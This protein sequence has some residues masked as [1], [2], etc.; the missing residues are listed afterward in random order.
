MTGNS[1]SCF[2]SNRKRKI[3]N[4]FNTM[5]TSEGIN[6]CWKQIFKRLDLSYSEKYFSVN[7]KK[8][9]YDYS[10]Q[11]EIQTTDDFL[12]QILPCDE[13]KMLSIHDEEAITWISQKEA[14][15]EPSSA[16]PFANI[17]ILFA[18]K[19]KPRSFASIKGNVLQVNADVIATIFF[20][21]TRYEEI[22]HQ[23]QDRFGRYPYHAS[24]IEKFSLIDIPIVDLYILILKGW[25]EK[26]TSETIANPKNF[27]ILLTH[28]IDM[29]FR[30]KPFSNF[31]RN[32]GKSILKFQI[33]GFYQNLKQFFRSYE[34]DDYFYGIRKI[35]ETSSRNGLNSVFNLMATTPGKR[36]EGYKL[37]SALMQRVINKI[38]GS[39][40]EIG[41]HPSFRS[42]EEPGLVEK[43]KITLEK[44]IRHDVKGGRQHYL[45]VKTPE[46]WQIWQEA[47]LHYDNSYTFAEHEGFRCGTCFPYTVFDV[48][49]NKELDFVELPLI[50]MDTTLKNYRKLSIDDAKERIFHLAK[51]CKFVGGCF[52]LLWHNSS[53]TQSWQKWGDEYADIIKGLSLLKVKKQK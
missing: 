47:G 45:R 32:A 30:N 18:K 24:V 19:A 11:P 51:I 34:D 23:G 2:H 41:L 28:D 13:Q 38:E 52:T 12:L 5:L 40:F 36:D 15:S 53:F 49:Q 48:T 17:P 26:L 21:L 10:K 6:Y 43:E 37:G 31:V 20:F 39:G 42:F 35:T 44:H 3:H 4:G 8:I 29:P 1:K 27:E 33:M 22:N 46:T 25:I 9:R 50:V 14:F 16:C 7:G